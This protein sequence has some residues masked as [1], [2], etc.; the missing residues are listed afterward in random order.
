MLSQV[1]DG[2]RACRQVSARVAAYLVSEGK[3]ACSDDPSAYCQA[4][5]RLAP[6]VIPE[7]MRLVARRLERD[8]PESQRWLGRRVHIVDGSSVSMPDTPANQ[9]AFPQPPQQSPGCGFPVARLTAIFSWSTAAVVDASMDSLNTHE[10]TLFHR[11][12]NVLDVGDVLLSDR[13]FCSYADIACLKKRGVD[14]VMRVH[15]S[16]SIDF[17]RG[18]RLGDH[19]H[20]VTWRKV[21]VRPSWM[22]PE[23]FAALPEEMTLREVQIGITIPG[24]RTRRITIVTPLLDSAAYPKEALTDLYR[25]RWRCEIDLRHLKTS[26][27]MDIL[28]GLSPDVVRKEV[29]T[30]LLAYNLIRGVMAAAAISEKV[31]PHRLSV[32]GTLQRLAVTTPLLNAA[33]SLRQ[34]KIL[35]HLFQSVAKDIVPDRPDRLEPRVRKRRPKVYPLLTC[36]RNEAR[37][38]LV[39]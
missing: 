35:A 18:K 31:S 11:I 2:D 15:A 33:S 17:R 22:S 5:K 27:R 19:D 9:R 37:R 38:R 25:Q 23:E 1:L 24:F 4:R 8:A 28:R 16:K 7:L 32:M 26:M 20:L 13:G 10:R 36:S 30:H 14:V 12:W 3:S 21:P 29:W 6:D 39:G 34:G